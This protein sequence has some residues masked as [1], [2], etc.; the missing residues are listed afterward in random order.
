MPHIMVTA[1]ALDVAVELHGP[2]DGPVAILLH[3]FPD[4]ARAWDGV[5]PALA[6]EGVRV[7]VP[8]LR[9]YGPT[10][11]RDAATPRSGQQAALGADLL[12]LMDAMGVGRAVLA[13]YDWGGR[14]ACIVAALWP[15]RVA[16]LISANGYNIQDIAASAQP[17]APE[18]E[19][20]YWYQW[21][22]HTE[23]GVR[24][25]EQDRRAFCRLLWRLWSPGWRFSE[26]EFDRTAASWD[27]PDFVATVVQSYRH[28]HRA[29]PGD[30][31]LDAIE[32]RL[33]ERPPIT[34]PAVVL[35]GAEDGVDPPGNSEGA[36][37]WFRGA[38]RREVVAGAG[39]FLPREAPQPWI[40]HAL[41]LM[42]AAQG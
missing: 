37:R 13:G 23:R 15:Q 20:R 5:A 42:A 22:L 40:V 10:R 39:H 18:Q 26:A 2:E 6:A 8:F 38:F 41:R 30:P 17:A 33:A 12:A 34:V 4:D 19:A 9:G 11:Y 35:H 1:G 16:G 28:R 27:N 24:G 7:V 32:A 3:G 21:Y 36:A 14:A 29:A 31:A 25:L